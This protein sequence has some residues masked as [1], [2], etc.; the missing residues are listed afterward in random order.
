MESSLAVLDIQNANTL[1][2]FHNLLE[3]HAQSKDAQAKSWRNKLEGEKHFMAAIGIP[4]ALLYH[5]ISRLVAN[6]QS[7]V[8]CWLKNNGTVILEALNV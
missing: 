3:S 7:V 5:G 4:N 6:A 1:K 2:T 8:R